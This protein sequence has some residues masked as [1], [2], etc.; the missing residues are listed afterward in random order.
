VGSRRPY[1]AMTNHRFDR[2]PLVAALAGV[3]VGV[4][5]LLGVSTTAASAQTPTTTCQ[6][7]DPYGCMGTTSTTAPG[8]VPS[9]TVSTSVAAVGNRVDV[10]IT[11]VPDGKTIDLNLGGRIVASGT[12]GASSAEVSA[13]GTESHSDV[14]LS[15]VVPDLP[16]GKY[17]LVATGAGFNCECLGGG[18]F[19]VLAA[20]TAAGSGR[21]AR[22][23]GSVAGTGGNLARTGTTVVGLLL[24]AGVLLVVGRTVLHGSRRVARR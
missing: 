16:P 1:D 15:F 10:T 21:N 6:P 3:V 13:A 23:G 17:A 12:A 18:G 24:A 20:G 5:L 11:N 19:E 7:S 9:C 8:V 4:T 22:S 2:S 14:A